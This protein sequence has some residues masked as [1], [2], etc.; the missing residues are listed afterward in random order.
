MGHFLPL[1]QDASKKRGGVYIRQVARFAGLKYFGL[2]L[3]E[4]FRSNLGQI[5]AWGAGRF[6]KF[7]PGGRP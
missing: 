7:F 5:R 3:R 6:D 4:W 2:S 1:E